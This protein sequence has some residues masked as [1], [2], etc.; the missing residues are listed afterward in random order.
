MTIT[1]VKTTTDRVGT[2]AKLYLNSQPA[3]ISSE[4][5]SQLCD[6]LMDEFQQLP[7][8]LQFSEYMRYANVEEMFGDIAQ[9]HLWVSAENYDSAVYSNPIYGLA[10]APSLDGMTSLEMSIDAAAVQSASKLCT[11]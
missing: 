9:S 3:D 8:D 7:L 10:L 4:I 11:W 2:L 5:I 1:P 6:W